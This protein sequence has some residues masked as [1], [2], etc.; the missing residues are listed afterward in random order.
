MNLPCFLTYPELT[1]FVH[2]LSL[3]MLINIQLPGVQAK[4]VVG[5]ESYKAS[6][7]HCVEYHLY[8]GSHP[9]RQ[10]M[11]YSHQNMDWCFDEFQK[12]F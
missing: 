12:L 2:G 3:L 9:Q 4:H 8:D 7:T 5:I 1:V 11:E 10:P 6:A